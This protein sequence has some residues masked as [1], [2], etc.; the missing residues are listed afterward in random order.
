MAKST[1][2]QTEQKT[3]INSWQEA[4]FVLKQIGNL[5]QMAKKHEAEMNLKITKIQESSQPLI[6]KVAEEKI[7]LERN[8][9]L[10]CESKREE[11]NEKKTKELSFGT[12]SFRIATPSLKTRKG[13][14][15]ESVKSIVKSSKKLAEKFIK[16]KEDLNKQAILNADLRDSDLE[17][18]GLIISQEESFYY[19]SFERK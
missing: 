8:L 10:F 16:V 1:K 5:S 4:D 3:T 18:I 13:F 7:G 15:W 6:D 11:F 19:E 17:K 9:Q 14:T 12:V 2:P